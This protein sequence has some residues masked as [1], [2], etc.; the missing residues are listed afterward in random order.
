[1]LSYALNCLAACLFAGCSSPAHQSTNQA[2][3][4]SEQYYIMEAAL[5]YEL[6]KHSANAAER[7]V[8]SGYILDCDGFTQE[9]V[10]ALRGYVPPVL[11][12][13]LA[14]TDDTGQEILDNSTG[15]HVKVWRVEI[16]EV[17]R[18]IATAYVFWNSGGLRFGSG[19]YTLVLQRKSGSWEVASETMGVA[20]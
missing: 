8:Y 14:T 1:M 7:D 12:D 17:R 3:G 9:L 5:R 18:N 13:A 20:P 10:R 19:S 16:A 4:R 11:A 6:G 2:P 15:K